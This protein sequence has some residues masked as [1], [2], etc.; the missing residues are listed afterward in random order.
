M[1][2]E[3]SIKNRI[4]FRARKKTESA[5]TRR[6]GSLKSAVNFGRSSSLEELRVSR[7]QIWPLAA[8]RSS[9][10]PLRFLVSAYVNTAS[11][12]RRLFFLSINRPLP[13]HVV[14]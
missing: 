14:V 3:I 12:D 1:K 6:R 7:L 11:S 4:M 8:R 2:N 9:G 13:S 10:E 5:K